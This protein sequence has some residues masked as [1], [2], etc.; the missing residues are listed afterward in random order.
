MVTIGQGDN[1]GTTIVATIY[2]DGTAVSLSGKTARFCMRLP[3]DAGYLRDSNCTVSGSE[4]TYTFDEAHAASVSGRTDEAYFEILSGSTTIYST[5]RFRVMVLRACDSETEAA[6]VWESD[7]EVWLAAKNAEFAGVLSDFGDD[8]DAELLSLHNWMTAKDTEIATMKSGA[9][10]AI[11]TKMQNVDTW[12]S[13][14]N[15]E[16]TSIVSS[17]ESEV[18]AAAQT[19]RTD[20]NDAIADFANDMNLFMYGVNVWKSEVEAD[21]TGAINSISDAINAEK[22]GFDVWMAAKDIEIA[23][24]MENVEDTLRDEMKDFIDVDDFALEQDE[25]TGLV[26]V[27]YRGEKGAN[28]IPLAG[29]GGGG[30]GGGGGAGNAAVLTV[31]NETGWLARTISRGSECDIVISWSSIEDNLETGDGTMTVTVGGIVKSAMGVSQGTVT[32]N[33]GPMLNTGTNKVK[34]R[35]S[36]V[37]DNSRTITFTISCAELVL[38]SD[39]DTSA[40]FGTSESILYTYTPT[41][42]SEKTVHFVV[43]GT[44]LT[45]SVVTVSG[46]QQ[47]KLLPS[48]S[49]GA[50]SLRVYFTATIDNQLVQSNELYYE[51][52]VVDPSSNTPIIASQFNQT[53][54]TQYDMLSIPYT[55]YTP[56]ALTST[57]QLIANG[58]VVNEISVGRTEQ[59]WSYR[60]TM[61]GTTTLSI[62]TGSVTKTFTVSVAASDIDVEAETQ[63]LALYLSSYGRSN[64]EATPS[65]WQDEDNNIA[66]TLTG[67]NYTA[68]GWVND[69]DGFTVL[70]V[71]NG[72]SVTIPYKPFESDFRSTGKTIEVEFAVRDVLDYDATALSCMS[73]GRGFSLTAQFATLASEQTSMTTQ[74]KEDEHVRVSFVVQKRN[75]N[76]LILIYINGIMSGCTQYPSNDDFSQQTPVN[77]AIGDDGITV[78]VYCIRIYD[79]DLTRYQIL[80][81]WIADTHSPELMLDRYRHNYVYNEYGDIVIERLPNDLPYMVIEAAELP[82]YKG[83]KK[84]VSGYYVDPV[85]TNKSFTFTGCQMNVQGTSSAPYYRKNWDLQF[86]SGFEMSDG[87]HADNYALAA[88]VIP[89]NRFVLKADVASSESAN[90]VE[91]V[92][93]YNEADQYTRPEKSVNPKVR[94]G[95][96]GFPIVM[97]WHDTTTD[98]TTFYS[99]MNFNLPKRA[100][101]PY[102]Y[103][104]DMESWEFQNNTSNLMLFLTDYFDETML[105]DPS[106]G[107]IKETWRYDYEARF[108]SDEW[109]DYAK[110]QELQSFVY[111]TYRANATGASLPSPVRYSDGFVNGEERFTTF[112]NDTAEYRLRRFR[113][114][115]GKYAEVNSFI[116]Y[117]IFTELF[118]MVDSRAK[119]LFIGF[120][121]GTATGTTAIDRKAIA[122]PYDMDTAIGTNNEGSL[123]FGYSLE[124][125][126]HLAGGANIF[127]GQN[128]VLWCNLRD[129]FPTEIA[130]MYQRLRS[131]GTLSYANVMQRFSEHQAKWPEAIFN[132]DAV[133]KYIEPLVSPKT[134]EPTAAYLPMLQGSKAEQRKWWLFNRFR[135]M[136]S[137]WMAGDATAHVIQVRAYAKANITVTPY[138]DIYTVIKYG[139]YYVSERGTHGVANTLACPI[140]TLNDTEIYIYSAP[141]LMN[142]GDL[143]PLKVG[144]AEFAQANKLTSIKVGS[145]DSGYTNPNLYYLGVGTNRL[146]ASVDA[147]NCTALT[148]NLDLSGAANI[149]HVYLVGTAVTSVDLPVG[150]ILKT[151]QLPSTITNLTVRD[152]PNITAFSMPSNDYSS[153]T[154]LRVEN[155]GSGIPTLAILEDMMPN[156]RVRIVGFTL[157]VSTTTDVENFYAY[158][159]T[160]R[161]LDEAGNTVNT[162]VV[163]GD[164]TGLGTITGAWLAQMNAR[165]PNVTIHYQHINSTLTYKSYDGQ[166]TL[167]TE[168]ITDGG[169]GTYSGTPTRTSTAQY[170]YAFAGWSLETD[171]LVA[172]P[173]ATKNV[174][175]DRTVYAAY[176]ATVR[177]YTI[178]WKN[179]NGTTLETDNN[180]PYGTMPTYNGATPTY[181]GQS[182]TGWS[183]AVAVVTGNQTYTATYL[184]QYT[185]R[186]Y[187][188]NDTLLQ[189][190]QVTQG[191]D[192]V[193]T[194]STPTHSQNF[195]FMGWDK[196][197]TNIQAATDFHAKFRDNR[198]I[199]LQYLY[200]TIDE[201]SGSEIETV[202][203]YA[204]YQCSALTTVS[205]P[206]CTSVGAYA[207]YQ[208]S[209]L[210]T[211]SLP[212]CTSVGGNAFY[213]CYSLTT[214]S[215]PV[216]TSVSGNAFYNCFALTTVS[217][218]SCTSV[219]SYAFANCFALTSVS[220][221][222]CTSVGGYAFD[223]CSALTTISLPVCTSVGGYAFNQ[224]YALTTVSLPVCTSVWGAAFY[225]CSALTTV[226]LPS[227]TTVGGNAFN[228][229]RSLTSVSLPVCTSVG[230]YAFYGCSALTTVNLP[231]C[232]SVGGSTFVSCY[233]LTSVSLP[234]CTSVGGS[235]FNQCY[236]L[237]A[238]HLTSVSRVPALG[239]NAFASTPIGGYTSYTDGQY[240]SVYVPASL[241][242][243]FLT[244]SN[245]SSIAD[246]IVSVA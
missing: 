237:T 238:L 122:E 229:C 203:D 131:N 63:S 62:K 53:A 43:D 221:P 217:L 128:S 154:T 148:D 121:G 183:P 170:T 16:M 142:V 138:S 69:P 7:Y 199:V 67:F 141:Q 208:C 49:H 243:D 106:T 168:T 182:A 235:A 139:S 240:G 59:I 105:A 132:E 244:A 120:S 169:N 26:Y 10:S 83:D 117:Y 93:L 236:S 22:Q 102:G 97:F 91:L 189:T 177:T 195:E 25:N 224:C 33:V 180:V 134:G 9:E 213:S 185:V 175:A 225:Q 210:T 153:I 36:D 145:G 241:Y 85:H 193:Y 39:F 114:E 60:C 57:V 92:K 111:S 172:N 116:F 2:D 204:F 130:T 212:V 147:R 197:L 171:Q 112:T 98:E 165:Y 149:E 201:V 143:S 137:K 163:A 190:S 181:N 13:A 71:N 55:V 23:S 4:I 31:T 184:P 90:N 119:N 8:L 21:V 129:A 191:Q 211:V 215:L 124:D 151:L 38:T 37:Y 74:Y 246:R 220:L 126:D 17:F 84:T 30:G 27:T 76:R 68:N 135:Y 52:I 103:S 219:G 186:F 35:V 24:A 58:H 107:D 166:T 29:T 200:N 14:K 79:N 99:K 100:P 96:Y 95:I 66:A 194:G 140:D 178:T 61:M 110:L 80:D 188:E 15:A 233:S 46:R 136:D 6:S 152:Q 86:K 228:S 50:H 42:A 28:G 56:N 64:G 5:S 232:T 32:V 242:S 82:Q 160:M 144:W 88:D 81:N 234:V 45:T 216:C 113:E 41:G 167:H 54:A 156:S 226:S 187:G 218:P 73:G 123:V 115:F 207:F 51:L 206:V 227:C 78:D 155:C 176:T 196:A 239:A 230:G 75:E 198:S 127:N 11:A 209:A 40:V 146:L 18:S 20:V 12:M 173:N 65:D 150:G 44:E 245:W 34:V 70:R 48:M 72:A 231:S 77:I 109:V 161:G 94:D 1:G 157:A 108:P 158:L 222:V 3:N 118:L 164:I 214:I 133:V 205:L 202:R 174:S 104:G 223:N 179:S 125:T 47:T 162:A 159:D 89:F 19:F 87:T 192:A 101:E